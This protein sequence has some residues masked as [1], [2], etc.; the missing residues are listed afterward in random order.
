MYQEGN[1]YVW[2]NGSQRVGVSYYVEHAP[3]NNRAWIGTILVNSAHRSAGIGKAIL[4]LI[5][6][7]LKRKGH[8]V[9]YAAVPIHQNKWISFLSSC[10]FEQYKLEKEDE[11]TYL[12]FVK[13]IE[14]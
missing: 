3:S 6:E 1:W 11:L 4:K 10:Q 7:K 8:K 5:T 9:V 12:L 2:L 13:P 14:A